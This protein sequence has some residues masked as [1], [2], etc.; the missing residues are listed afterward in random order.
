MKRRLFQAFQQAPWRIQI[1][2]IG[3]VLLCLVCVALTA[4][5]Y[6]TITANTYAAGVFAQDYDAEKEK[7]QREIADINTRISLATTEEMM[8][9]RAKALGFETANTY[10]FVYIVVPGYSGR[11]IRV[12][13]VTTDIEQKHPSLIKPA[14]QE[15]L[16][17][18]FFQFTIGLNENVKRGM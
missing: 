2:R 10:D 8:T 4:G 3:L 1:Q 13:T 16:W 17:E 15:S 14:Y 7:L 9:R 11:H 18:W 5:V 12:S 6:L